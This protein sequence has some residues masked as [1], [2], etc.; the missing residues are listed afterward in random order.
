MAGFAKIGP[1]P[2]SHLLQT[3]GLWKPEI[4]ITTRNNGVE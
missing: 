4:K 2:Q 1:R 3:G